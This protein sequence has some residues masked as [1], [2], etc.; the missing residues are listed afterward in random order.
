MVLAERRRAVGVFSS[1]REAEA[2]LAE[3]RDAG[4]PMNDVSVIARNENEK[5]DI[6]DNK[7]IG[8]EADDGAKIG[9]ITGTTLGIIGGLLASVGA[10]AVPVIG[11]AGIAI[12]GA[13]TIGGAVATTLAGAGAG[14][15][16]GGLVGALAG[17]GI[18]EE[19]AKVYADHIEKGGYVVIV[20]GTDAEIQRAHQILNNRGI[21]EW[22][23]YDVNREQREALR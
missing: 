12:W 18:P 1:H 7:K 10:I 21:R 20:D 11:G 16:A 3:L 17:L 14:A 13:E 22:G 19:R 6:V 9:A 15:I 4:F 5:S 2:A 8:N 23:V